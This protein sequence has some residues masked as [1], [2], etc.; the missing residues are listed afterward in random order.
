MALYPFHVAA[1][2]SLIGFPF[3]A[4]LRLVLKRIHRDRV[5]AHDAD[6][7]VDDAEAA[8]P[9]VPLPALVR[10]NLQ[11]PMAKGAA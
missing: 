1:F 2:P 4:C 11:V 9:L 7:G 10:L 6:D 5:A 3:A 8:P